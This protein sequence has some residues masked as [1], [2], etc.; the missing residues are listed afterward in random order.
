MSVLQW[1]CRL[2]EVISAD[3]ESEGGGGLWESADGQPRNAAD[4]P[5][6]LAL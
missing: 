6:D 3:N 1:V 2:A 4:G 5:A